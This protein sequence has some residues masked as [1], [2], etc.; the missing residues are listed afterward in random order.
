MCEV[1]YTVEVGFFLVYERRDYIAVCG[2]IPSF[3]CGCCGYWNAAITPR[4]ASVVSPANPRMMNS[5]RTRIPPAPASG[6]LPLKGFMGERMIMI[7]R[8]DIPIRMSPMIAGM[9]IAVPLGVIC[10]WGVCLLCGCYM[11]ST[12][13]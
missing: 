6:P 2:V 8:I 5:V 4:V 11:V 13:C 9:S 12:L 1:I 10:V 7:P 3:C